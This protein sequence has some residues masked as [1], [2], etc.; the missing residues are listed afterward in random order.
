VTSQPQTPVQTKTY[1]VVE[2]FGPTIQGEGAMAGAVTHFIRFGGCDFGCWWCDSAHAV[3]PVN[4]RGA[5]RLSVED[6]LDRLKILPGKPLWVTL[7]GGNPALHDLELLTDELHFRGFRVAIETQGSKWRDWINNVDQMTISPKPPSS[8][9]TNKDF[10]QFMRQ[11]VAKAN[12]ILKVPILNEEDFNFAKRLHAMYSWYPFYL[13]VVNLMGGLHGDFGGGVI[14]TL[15]TYA[16]RF[17]WLAELTSRDS[18]MGAVRVIP[19]LHVFAW[20]N[21]RGR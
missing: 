21:D 10:P 16:K 1:P 7:S 2:I 8:G 14:D 3:L 5:D 13:S 15:E 12:P 11:V 19:Q 4:V 18:D 17:R 9:Q 6:I 20:G